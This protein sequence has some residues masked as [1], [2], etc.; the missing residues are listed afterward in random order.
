MRIVKA[1][2]GYQEGD[3]RQKTRFAFLP[4]VIMGTRL[5]FKFYVATEE[6]KKVDALPPYYQW[7]TVSLIHW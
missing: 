7:E 2:T 3:S 6:L 1:K 5:W 4:V